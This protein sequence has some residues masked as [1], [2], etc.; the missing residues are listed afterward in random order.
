MPAEAYYLL[1]VAALVAVLFA[2]WKGSGL[3]LK[4]GRRGVEIAV[5]ERSQ[6]APAA[7]PR[8]DVA[9]GATIEGS[10]TGDIAGV[11][12]RGAGAVPPAGSDVAVLQRGRVKDSEV[13][14]IAGVKQE[15][16]AQPEE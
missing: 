16:G 1:I 12:V 6:P 8:I 3:S 14:D 10:K 15:D 9:G 5:K 2:I 4:K 7:R 11:I 13:G